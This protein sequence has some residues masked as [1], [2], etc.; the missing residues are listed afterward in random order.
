MNG[1]LLRDGSA[2]GV[3]VQQMHGANKELGCH[4]YIR[5]TPTVLRCA[6]IISEQVVLYW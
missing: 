1:G 4:G 2:H 5:D 6:Q 3:K